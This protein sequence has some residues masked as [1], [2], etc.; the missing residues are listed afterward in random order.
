MNVQ[1]SY[2]DERHGK[3]FVVP[4]PIGNLDDMTFRA[5][6]TIKQVNVV[7]AED[8]RH[9]KKLLHHF[10]IKQALIS[11]HEH[12]RMQ[13]IPQIIE[14]LQQGE[15]IALVSDAGTPGISDPGFE[16]VEAVIDADYNVIVLPGA[17]AAVT[18]LV[19]S[20][21]SMQP[22][23]FY[24]FLPRKQRALETVLTELSDE[25]ATLLFYESP[26][27]LLT[28]LRA[29]K[30]HFHERH[31]VIAR[32]LTKVYE[33]Y[34]R[35]TISEVIDYIKRHPLR[36]ECV[37][38]VEGADE[39]TLEKHTSLWW[40]SLTIKQHVEHYEREKGVSHKEAMRLVAKDRQLSRRDIYHQLH[41]K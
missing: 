26:N 18:A 4:T 15:Q 34:I 40:S 6:D 13:R 39:V 23:L 7:L 27:R 12:N 10:Q 20:G 22:F 19:G 11:Y 28:T 8:T 3:L 21:L 41:V 25:R 38:I 2:K 31:V 30:E 35:G 32:E 9:T 33:Q 14:K 36:G 1:N 29:M 16:L 37:L 17:N 5:V 24:G